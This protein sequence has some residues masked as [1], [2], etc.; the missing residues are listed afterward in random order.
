M[1]GSS[2]ALS[3]CSSA[4]HYIAV[5]DNSST[6]GHIRRGERCSRCAAEVR[7]RLM[8]SRRK[9]LDKDAIVLVIDADVASGAV[10]ADFV[11]VHDS[12]R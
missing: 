12:T 9:S 6:P 3:R 2:S 5:V 1:K 7:Q 10:G 4:V 8:Q 11:E